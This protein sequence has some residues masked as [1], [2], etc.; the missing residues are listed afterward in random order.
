MKILLLAALTLTLQAQQNTPHAGYVYP[1]GGRQGD[2]LEVIVGGQFLD[3]VNK[4]L[5]SGSGVQA[6]ISNFVKPLTQGQFNKLREQ[7]QELMDKKKAGKTPWTAADDMNVADLRNKIATFIRRPMTP[8]IAENV[9]I[10]I[11]LDPTAATGEREL[12]LVTPAGVTNPIVFC[13]GQLP[14]I[15]K[16]AAKVV[17]ELQKKTPK[18]AKKA[19]R[20]QLSSQD[21]PEATEITLPVMINGQA[22]PGGLDRYRFSANKGQHV[23]VAA[24]VREL[25]PYISDAVPGWFQAAIGLYDSTGKE[26]S[27]ADHYGFHQDPVLYYEIPAD[28]QYTLQIHDSIYRGREDFVYRIAVGQFPYITSI[29]PLGGRAGVKT[30][31]AVKGWNLP[32]TR[33]VENMKSAGIYPIAVNSSNHLPFAVDSL[34]EVLAREPNK[35]PATAQRVKL[36]LIVNGRIEKPGDLG[37]FRFEGRAGEEI[38]AEVMARRLDSPLDS[39]LKLTDAKGRQIAMNDDY[40]D[41]GAALITHQADSFIQVK[42]PAAGTYYLSIGDTQHKGGP[43]YAYRLRISHP[44]QDYQLRMTPASISARGG[45]SVPVTVY[46][47]RKDGFSGEIELRLK[48]APAGFVLSGGWIPAGQANARMTLTLPPRKMDGPVDLHLEGRSKLEGKDVVR[49]GIPAED[50]MQAFYYHHL[51]AEDAWVAR[52]AAPGPGNRGSPAWKIMTDKRVQIPLDG[53]AS[54]VKVFLPLGRYA[55]DVKLELNDPPEGIVIDKVGL[56]DNG[57]NIFLKN[58]GK[59]K[60]GLAGNLL[61]DAFIDLENTAN[62]A[63]KKRRTALGLLP[64]IPFTVAS[65]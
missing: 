20:A 9:H 42:L 8:A 10:Q 57:V 2:T 27:Y 32:P 31:V 14:E 58:T 35:T 4:V 63:A 62:V 59:A 46:A 65:N 1:A 51:V 25:I 7:L 55:P 13:V 52:V 64:A 17:S 26:V 54:P 44:M 41:K 45:Q 39:I 12:R 23:V 47:L 38:V 19:A 29:F 43:D 30:Q 22:T 5:I 56:Y 49:P 33:L 61:V 60:P 18:S 24:N 50:M 40:E 6:G 28:G 15:S 3:G 53:S 16:Q 36:P 34:P 11:T 21:S 48:D 37:V